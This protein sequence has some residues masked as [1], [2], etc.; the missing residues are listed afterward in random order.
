VWWMRDGERRAGEVFNTSG[1]GGSLENQTKSALRISRN[2]KGEF[3]SNTQHELQTCNQRPRPAIGS[4]R[5]A[6]ESGSRTVVD[7]ESAPV[8]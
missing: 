8:R 7:L 1:A 4:P 6:A 2:I 5:S 3:A